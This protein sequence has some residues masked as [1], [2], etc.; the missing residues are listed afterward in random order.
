MALH[1]VGA[2]EP[3]LLPTRL[4]LLPLLPPSSSS[5]SSSSP[6]TSTWVKAEAYLNRK[7]LWGAFGFH[8]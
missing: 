2:L 6:S 5:S 7:L 1:R 3:A 8:R 4:P